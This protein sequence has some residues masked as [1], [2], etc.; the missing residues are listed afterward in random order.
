MSRLHVALVLTALATGCYSGA[1]VAVPQTGDDPDTSTDGEA[2]D[3]GEPE[4]E[5]DTDDDVPP[6]GEDARSPRLWRL[7]ASQYERT[8]EGALGVEVALPRIRVD[9]RAEDFTNYANASGVDEVFFANLEEDL[10]ELISDNRDAIAAPLPCTVDSLDAVCLEAFLGPFV[11]RAHRTDATDLAPYLALYEDLSPAQGRPDA[12]ASVLVAVLL[13]PKALFR[14]ELGADDAGPG[15]AL[16]PFEL[17]ENLSYAVWN[18]PPDE[19]LFA[20]AE[21]GSLTDPEVFTAHLDRML[22]SPQGNEG[23]VEFLSQWLG[24]TGLGGMGKD[25][26][27]FPEFDDELRAAMIQETRDL[28]EFVLDEPGADL[29]TLLTTQ[30]SFAGAPLAA[31]YGVEPLADGSVEL[32]P[33]QRRGVFTTAG[34]VVAMSDASSTAVIY[35]GKAL[36]NRMLCRDLPPRPA[37]VE[38]TPPPGIPEDATTREKLESI[39]EQVPCNTCHIDMH[40][41]SFAMEQYDAVGRFRETQNGHTI[42]ASGQ[43]FIPSSGEFVQFADVRELIDQLAEEPDVYDCLVKQ[44]VRYTTG[45]REQDLDEEEL[46]RITDQFRD[47]RNIRELFRELVL[48][49][50]FRDRAKVEANECFSP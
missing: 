28:F 40:P 44:G 21:D 15:A 3:D 48:T 2:G 27:A 4:D 14:T 5:T 41:F 18:G 46:M 35:R 31:L 29:K 38:P 45:D 10:F 11:R 30:K 12:F 26:T 9:G 8:V 39:E 16:T 43:L 42:D 1:S 25:P 17:A 49:V 32:P 36:L 20:A 6:L 23:M 7:S 22:D 13:S 19:A 50:A 24:L 34:V 47:S 37:G 33:D